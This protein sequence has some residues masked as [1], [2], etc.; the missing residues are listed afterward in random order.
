MR[1][2]G[3]SHLGLHKLAFEHHWPNHGVEERFPVPNGKRR[4]FM[5]TTTPAG[6]VR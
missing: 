5:T 6:L 4:R 3:L 1:L 2:E